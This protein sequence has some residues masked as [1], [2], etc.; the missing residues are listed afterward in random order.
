MN[1]EDKARRSVVLF[2]IFGIALFIFG[3]NCTLGRMI[4]DQYSIDQTNTSL[5]WDTEW[6]LSQTAYWGKY[7]DQTAT[8]N[9]ATVNRNYTQDAATRDAL[10]SKVAATNVAATATRAVEST[11][12]RQTELAPKP[13]RIIDISFPSEIPGNKSTIIGLLYFK[14]FDGDISHVV[15]RVVTAEHFVGGTDFDPKLDSGT[16]KDGAIKIY[17]WCEGK[18]Y[19]TMEATIVDLAGNNSSSVTFSFTCK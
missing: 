11:R 1:P 16:W 10:S 9:Q 12:A 15:Y 18:Q 6:S 17:M 3:A 14:D 13:P 8:A 19:V 7:N 4:S 2:L 5:A